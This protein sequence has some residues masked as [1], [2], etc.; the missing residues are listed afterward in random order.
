MYKKI[1]SIILCLVVIL[2]FSACSVKLGSSSEKSKDEKS[3]DKKYSSSSEDIEV[4]TVSPEI[5][6]LL[7]DSKDETVDKKTIYMKG[8]ATDTGYENSS[9]KLKFELPD[10][11]EKTDLVPQAEYCAGTKVT[12]G[13]RSICFTHIAAEYVGTT[14]SMDDCIDTYKS[15]LQ[16]AAK[17]VDVKSS[18]K[19]EE[20]AGQKWR[21]MECEIEMEKGKKSNVQSYLRIVGG[22]L[23]M[24]SFQYLSGDED[25][26]EE[27]KAG[28]SKM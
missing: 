10:G 1:L 2:S 12:A 21:Y 11:V 3:D 6:S 28:Y 9:L 16:L 27:L 20:L 18:D 23:V 7:D 8:K 19:T 4:P 24:I 13:A 17:S 5:D 14:V 25:K 22:K 15:T 26:V